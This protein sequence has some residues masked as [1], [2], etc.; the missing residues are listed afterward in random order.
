MLSKYYGTNLIY[1]IK[2]LGKNTV[3]ISKVHFKISRSILV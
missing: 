2:F 1:E 3:G